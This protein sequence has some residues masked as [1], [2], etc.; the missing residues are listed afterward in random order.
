MT[1][2][3]ALTKLSYVLSKDEWDLDTKR[4]MMMTSLRGELTVPQ[5]MLVKDLELFEAVARSLHMS[6]SD[7]MDRLKDVL[8]PT[9]LCSA[10]KVLNFII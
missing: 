2:E 10:V 6:S 5:T 3:A 4:Q 9:L 8:F 7:E 1:P